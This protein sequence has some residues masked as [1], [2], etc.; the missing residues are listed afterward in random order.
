[1]SLIGSIRLLYMS[2]RE[3]FWQS[4]KEKSS[5]NVGS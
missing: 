5:S 1:M 2:V 3:E 4:G